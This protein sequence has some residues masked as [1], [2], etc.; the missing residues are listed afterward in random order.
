MPLFR[1][2]ADLVYARG[3]VYFLCAIVAVFMIAHIFRKLIPPKLA[4]GLFQKPKGL[5]RYLVYRGFRIASFSL[6]SPNVGRMLV[7]SLGILFFSG[8]FLYIRIQSRIDRLELID[9]H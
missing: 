8:L 5:M 4:N 1:Y 6:L 9:V 3:T 2:V 7:V